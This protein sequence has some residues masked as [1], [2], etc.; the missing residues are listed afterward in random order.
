MQYVKRAAV[1]LLLSSIGVYAADF[2]WIEYRTNTSTEGIQSVQ[3][4]RYYAVKIKS[5]KTEYMFDAPTAEPCVASL[6]PH[7]G[8]P[9]CWYL[10]RH[11][12][13]RVDL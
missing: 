2:A 12:R 8:R 10:R 13:R 11:T 7:W 4:Q 1:F 6:F 9:P 3:I 5:G